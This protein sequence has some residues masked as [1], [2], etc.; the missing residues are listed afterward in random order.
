MALLKEMEK[1]GSRVSPDVLSYSG[2][3]SCIA[4]GERF[5]DAEK[6]E[7]VLDRMTVAGDVQP[8]NGKSG[9]KFLVFVL[10]LSGDLPSRFAQ[11]HNIFI[12]VSPP[13]HHL[14]S[15]FQP[16]HEHL[17]QRRDGGIVKEVRESSQKDG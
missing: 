12:F 15:Y 10:Q 11:T 5:E 1:S 8:D 3:I 13:T 16:G 2:V 4:K 14:L 7:D 17:Q 6:A 9:R